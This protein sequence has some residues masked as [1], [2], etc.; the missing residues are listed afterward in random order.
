MVCDANEVAGCT[1]ANATN[2]DPAATD[3]NGSCEYLTAGCTDQTACNFD[4]TAQEEDG[5][6]DYDTC[7]GC[8]V[9]WAC[10]YDASATLN[11]GSCVFPDV[12]GVCPN[13]CESDL[14]GDGICDVNEVAGCTYANAVNY[15]AAA[16]DDDG[17]CNFV[18]CVLPDYSSYNELANTNSGDCTNAPGSADFTGDGLVQLEDLLDFLVSFGTSGP[19]WGIDW[20]QNGCSVVPMGIAEMDVATTGCTYP[21]ASNYDASADSD[22]GSC[23]WL[24]CTDQEAY[25]YNHLATLDDS[26][27]TYNICPDFNGDGQVQTQDLLDFLIAWGAVYE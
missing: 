15:D 8:I 4:F 5:S 14:D 16:T 11:D 3:D 7:S 17:T 18:G 21:T 25:N 23:V 13:G 6:C 22:T 27:C 19:D 12:N 24:G 20:V 10:N 9:S 2:F 26:S 1:D